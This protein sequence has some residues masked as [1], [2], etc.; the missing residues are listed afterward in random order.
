MKVLLPFLVL[1]IGCRAELEK[2]EVSSDDE[3]GEITWVVAKVEGT[4]FRPVTGDQP[5]SVEEL[6]KRKV[7][8]CFLSKGTRVQFVQTGIKTEKQLR[9]EMKK[10]EGVTTGANC[11]AGEEGWLTRADFKE[12]TQEKSSSKGSGYVVREPSE[13][14]S[15]QEAPRKSSFSFVQCADFDAAGNALDLGIQHFVTSNHLGYGKTTAGAKLNIFAK[16]L[17]LVAGGGYSQFTLKLENGSLED[18]LSASRNINSLIFKNGT[19]SAVDSSGSE[20][21][22]AARC[23][24]AGKP[25]DVATCL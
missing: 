13:D 12:P 6:E 24:L 17:C 20:S 3:K 7:Y 23:S 22:I 14:E 8:P 15:S 21:I 11:R 19:L 2:A 10:I 25:S 16:S 18:A 9:V 5:L 4:H 1:L